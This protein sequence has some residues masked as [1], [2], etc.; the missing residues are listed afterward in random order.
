MGYHKHHAIIITGFLSNRN[1]ELQAIHDFA[2]EIGCSI[3]PISEEVINGFQSF[4]VYP[5]GS[6]DGWTS[7]NEGDERRDKLVELLRMGHIETF[8]VGGSY[9]WVEIMYGGDDERDLV[10]RSSGKDRIE[11]LPKHK[12]PE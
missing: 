7:S 10:T 4:V 8:Y 3:S 1:Q 12:R 2:L 6:K 9:D 5:D 11:K